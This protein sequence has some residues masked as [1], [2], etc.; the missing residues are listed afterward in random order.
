MHLI[1]ATDDGGQD[2][3]DLLGHEVI[4][5]ILFQ[6]IDAVLQD[7]TSEL[8]IFNRVHPMNISDGAE[9]DD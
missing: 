5:R 7:L 1:A 4:I 9:S 8:P 2:L 6:T 3:K